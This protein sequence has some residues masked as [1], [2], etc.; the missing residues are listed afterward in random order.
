MTI[1]TRDFG[2][3]EINESDIITFPNGVYAFEETRRYVLLSPLGE[4]VFPMWL[5]CLDNSELCFIVFNPSELVS[6]YSVNIA[7]A[8]MDIVGREGEIG[9]L[10]IAVIPDNY[11]KTTVNLKSPIILNSVGRLAVQIVAYE[12]YNIKH[13]VFSKGEG[14]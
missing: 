5:Q 7:D 3:V 10:C 14:V 13:P 12:D 8:D 4:D 11:L 6:G 1:K 9:Y 2:E